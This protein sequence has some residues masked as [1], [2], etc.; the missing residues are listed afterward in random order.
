MPAVAAADEIG[1]LHAQVEDVETTIATL[2]ALALEQEQQLMQQ[3]L[4]LQQQA[5]Q[6]QQQESQLQNQESQHQQQ[7]Q[8]SEQCSQATIRLLRQQLKHANL[9]LKQMTDQLEQQKEQSMQLKRNV[10][11]RSQ[12]LE[13]QRQLAVAAQ[14]EAASGRKAHTRL[15]QQLEEARAELSRQDTERLSKVVADLALVAP[16]SHSLPMKHS[17]DRKSVLGLPF[18]LHIHT[19]RSSTMCTS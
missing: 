6:L 11:E 14:A 19:S 10:H 5:S 17:S 7:Q 1:H 8:P 3:Q 16:Y 18:T 9:E 15:A 4:Q 12:Q 2:R 13:K